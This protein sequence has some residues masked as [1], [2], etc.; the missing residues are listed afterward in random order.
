MQESKTIYFDT[1]SIVDPY[2]FYIVMGGRGCGKS[3]GVQTAMNIGK[4]T[5]YK[6]RRYSKF[7]AIIYIAREWCI[8]HLLLKK[9]WYKRMFNLVYVFYPKW[10]LGECRHL[11]C[12]CQYKHECFN[13]L[14]DEV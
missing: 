14:I 4:R 7:F 12:R 8:K 11:C 9:M 1:D 13:N 6:N 5:E 3:T 2:D 10:V